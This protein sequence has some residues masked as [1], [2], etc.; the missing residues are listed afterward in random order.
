[1]NCRWSFDSDPASPE[2]LILQRFCGV[3]IEPTA[4]IR[5]AKIKPAGSTTIR[6]CNK[7]DANAMKSSKCNIEEPVIDGRRTERGAL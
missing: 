3:K 4:G 7:N 1:M 5:P 2:E 6:S